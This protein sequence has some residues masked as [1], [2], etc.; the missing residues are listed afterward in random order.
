MYRSFT[1]LFFT[2][3]TIFFGCKGKEEP[4]KQSQQSAPLVDVIIAESKSISNIIEANGTVVANEF[5]ELHPEVSGRITYLNVPE[6][7]FVNKGT[8]IAR[9]NDDDLRAQLQKS[10]V[11]LELAQQTVDRLQKLLDIGGVNQADYD[12]ALNSANGLK[13]DIQYTQAL[14]DKTFIKAPFSGVVGLRQVSIGAY[15]SNANIIATM[16]QV[17]KLKVDF[18]IPEEYS[19]YIKVGSTINMQLDAADS[20]RH[21]ATVIAVE[22]QANTLTRNIKA[23]TILQDNAKANPGAFVKVYLN[24]MVNKKAIMIPTNCIIPNDKNKQVV[25]VDSGKAKFVNI[26]TG[27]RQASNVEIIT[28]LNTGDSVVVTGVLFARAKN[29]V[30]VRSVKKLE[31]INN[32]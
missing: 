32:Q 20:N 22:P 26:Q 21:K 8:L 5:V 19:N 31:D 11:Q 24:A 30:K 15:V 23:R 17:D 29:P 2:S 4:P 3:C 10:K 1:F 7:K 28:G 25:I 12:A 6:G 14:I 18:T 27:I 13:A 9:I 16:Q